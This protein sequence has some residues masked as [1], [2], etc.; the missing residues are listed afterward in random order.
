MIPWSIVA[1][2]HVKHPHDVGE[3]ES[4]PEIPSKVHASKMGTMLLQAWIGE[5]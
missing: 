1:N 5:W 4:Q 2:N 3:G